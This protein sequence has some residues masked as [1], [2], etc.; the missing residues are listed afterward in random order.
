VRL[1]STRVFL[2]SLLVLLPSLLNVVVGAWEEYWGRLGELPLPLL[3]IWNS[4]S[5]VVKAHEKQ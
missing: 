5:D 2:P 4:K 3:V 1:F